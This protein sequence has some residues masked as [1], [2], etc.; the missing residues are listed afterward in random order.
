MSDEPRATSTA[1]PRPRSTG[2]ELPSLGGIVFGSVMF[3]TGWTLIM[4][5]FLIPAGLLL[6]AA[7][8]GLMLEPDRRP[9]RR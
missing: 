1:E 3:I 5:V 6:F 8:L 7:G 9:R 4:T 2:P